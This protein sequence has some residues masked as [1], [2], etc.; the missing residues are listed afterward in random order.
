MSATPDRVVVLQP[1]LLLDRDFIDYPYFTVLGAAQAT[2]MLRK[3]IPWVEVMDGL[4]GPG[5]DLGPWGEDEAWLGMPEETFLELLPGLEGAAV[6]VAGSPFLMGQPGRAWLAR[7][8]GA[9]HEA[10]P[11]T[12]ALAEM[13]VGG[14]HYLDTKP[15]R[16]VG[17]LPGQPLLM[18]HECEAHLLR[19]AAALRKGERPADEVWQDPKPP[20]LERLPAPAWDLMR[21]EPMFT[22]FERA[23]SSTWRPG[24]VPSVPRW[25]LPLI[26]ARGC[27]YS[28]VF[29]TSNPGYSVPRAVRQVPMK[30][31]EAWVAGWVADHGLQRLVLLDE[32]PN[33]RAGRFN[34]LLTMCEHHGLGLELPNG[35]RADRLDEDQVQRLAGLSTQLKVSL[36]SASPRVQREVLGKNLDPA[37]VVRVAEWCRQANLP[38]QVHC[39]IGIPGESRQEIVDTLEM[40]ADLREQYGAEVLMQNATPLAGTK[41]HSECGEQGLLDGDAERPWSGFQRRGIISTDAFDPDLLQRARLALN[42][43]L[44]PPPPTKVIVNLTYRCNNHCV[45]CAVANR[46]ARDAR[47]SEV[48]AQLRRHR[49]AGCDLLDL[50]GGEPTMH[51]DLFTILRAASDMGYQRI[52][53]ITNG[54]R[55]SYP[56]YARALVLA[57]VDEVLISLHASEAVLNEQITGA[58]TA[59]PQTVAGITGIL[60]V[61]RDPERVAINTTVTA[62]N[63]DALPELG[64]L[65]S[66]LGVGRWNLQLV[67]PFGRATPDLLPDEPAL[68]RCLEGILDAPPEGVRVQL[69]NCPPC[70]TPNHPEAAAAD[71]G[72]IHRSMVFVDACGENLQSYLGERREHTERCEGCVERINCPGEYRFEP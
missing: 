23:M 52:A 68:I 37:S 71:F 60:R 39:I 24:P 5:A 50:D 69:V 2:A 26:T 36:E 53:L 18:R 22:L 57:G 29:C 42:T 44:A 51:E 16:W 63:L 25:T 8:M 27:P 58:P 41:L 59:F 48:I 65:V 31:V 11:A 43:R 19:W 6:L 15:E 45:F 67:T 56:S 64:R 9:L 61:M 12:V 70:L 17:A 20:S 1:P 62:L 46:E 30:R 47:A 10:R 35:V 7:L 3:L 66:Q 49:D 13:Y 28:C 14:M 72:K 21:L 54:R 34:R 40:A 33:L 4:C 38:L 32:V 55:L